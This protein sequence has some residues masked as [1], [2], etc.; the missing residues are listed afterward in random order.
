MKKP[1]KNKPD[2]PEQ[3][4]FTIAE[5]AAS[6]K[7]TDRTIRN[8]LMSGRLKAIRVGGVIRISRKELLI[9]TSQNY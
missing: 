5:V 6:L 1:W 3:D 9:F 4:Y 2:S 7:V 8:W